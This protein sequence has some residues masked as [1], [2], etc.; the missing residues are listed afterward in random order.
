VGIGNCRRTEGGV[1]CPSYMVTREEKHTTRGRAHLLF[2]MLQGNPVEGGWRNEEVHEALDLCLACKG[3]TSDCPVSVDMPTLKA[4]FLSHYYD[5]RLRPRHAYAFGLIDQAARLA[6]RAPGVVNFLTH[7][8]SLSR[9]AKLAADISPQREIPAFAST[10]LQRWFRE[11]GGPRNETGAKVLLW[12]DTFTNYFHP[13]VGIA[14]VEVLERAGY[15]VDVPEMHVC[16][17][18]PLYDFGLLDLARR[19]LLRVLDLLREDIRAGVPVV[20]VEPSC[21]ATFKDELLKMLPHDE[22]A[23]RLCKQSFHFAQFLEQEGYEPPALAR[24]ALLHGHCHHKATGGVEGEQK[25]LEKM[26]VEVEAPDTGCCGLAGSFGF[27][28]D[29]Y[30]ISMACGERVLLPAVREA[31]PDTIVVADGFSCRTQIEQG[32][33]GRRAL[34]VAEVVKLAYDHGA[35]GPAGPYPERN[36]AEP[37]SANG[38]RPG[39]VTAAV[40]TAAL[41][42]GALAWRSRS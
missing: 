42:A 8:P 31:A 18:R 20:G 32:R 22:D 29:H 14:A 4:E 27:V 13:E 2:E 30:D 39:L 33:T 16:C 25:L 36:Q 23:A 3:C 17:G 21:L 1:M 35:G 19:Y 26:G 40:L 12:P 37:P 38:H 5:G 41:A 15:R 6:S 11:R 24:T 28:A 34:H 9:I 10:T 7:T